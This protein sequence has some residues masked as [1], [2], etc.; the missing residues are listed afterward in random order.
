LHFPFI[1]ESPMAEYIPSLEYQAKT[2]RKIP[3]FVAEPKR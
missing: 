3:L 2:T 1:E